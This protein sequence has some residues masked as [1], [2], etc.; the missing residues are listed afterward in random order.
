MMSAERKKGRRLPP[1]E[2]GNKE[3][4]KAITKGTLT[5]LKHN[6]KSVNPGLLMQFSNMAKS[7][8][9]DQAKLKLKWKTIQY[10]IENKKSKAL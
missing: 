10:L 1:L 7:K 9:S 5:V 6:S 3:K 2:L 8:L 4:P